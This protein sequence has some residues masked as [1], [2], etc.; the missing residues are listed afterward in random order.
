[1]CIFICY[2]IIYILYILCFWTLEVSNHSTR[3]TT[4]CPLCMNVPLCIFHVLVMYEIIFIYDF[5]VAP[6]AY[7]SQSLGATIY[8]GT[9]PYAFPYVYYVVNP[10]Y[11]YTPIIRVIL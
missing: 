7:P 6:L 11:V 3:F 5:G 2:Y 4:S 8:C 9:S 1:M 10:L